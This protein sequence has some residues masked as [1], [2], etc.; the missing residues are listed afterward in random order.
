MLGSF[1]DRLLIALGSGNVFR[2]EAV[3]DTFVS[4]GLL[5][6]SLPCPGPSSRDAS[7]TASRLSTSCVSSKGTVEV[8]RERLQRTEGTECTDGGGG[9]TSTDGMQSPCLG[10]LTGLPPRDLEVPE[11]MKRKTRGAAEHSEDTDS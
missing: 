6:S 10:D 7:V 3:G 2:L 1:N 5:A 8:A 11:V 4:A 9:N